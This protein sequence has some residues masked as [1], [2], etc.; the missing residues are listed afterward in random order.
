M[1]PV[2]RVGSPALECGSMRAKDW[3]SLSIYSL[4]L[5]LLVANLTY[6]FW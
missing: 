4:S 5:V 3:I 2:S 1:L 6:R